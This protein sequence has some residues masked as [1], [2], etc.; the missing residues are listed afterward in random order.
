MTIPSGL[1]PSKVT[2]EVGVHVTTVVHN[3]ATVKVMKNG[4]DITSFL[5]I[6]NDGRAASPL[7]AVVKPAIAREPL[8]P[9]KGAVITLNPSAPSFTTPATRPGL[10]YTLR[11]GVSLGT[12][13]NGASK[14]GDGQPWTPPV[15]VKGGPSGF[16]SIKVEK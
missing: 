7:A 11:E 10:T 5:D 12:M 4:H 3:G 16:Y 14:V 13:A 9:S 6:P 15:T 8:D 1:D 2:I